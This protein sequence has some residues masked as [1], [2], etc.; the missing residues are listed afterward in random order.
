MIIFNSLDDPEKILELGIVLE[1]ADVLIEKNPD[2]LGGLPLAI[3][4]V[5]YG[6]RSEAIGGNFKKSMELYRKFKKKNQNK[7]LVADFIIFR[8]LSVEKNDQQL[9]ENQYQKIMQ[10]KIKK[11]NNLTFINAMIKKKAMEYY[12]K[13]NIFF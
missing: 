4:M 11:K 5:Y 13:K 2:Y 12:L 10:F 8:Y 1:L 7:S 6:G 3:P 9:F